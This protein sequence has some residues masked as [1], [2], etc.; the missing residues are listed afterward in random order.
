M[1]DVNPYT[2]SSLFDRSA[3]LPD[4]SPHGYIVVAEVLL[5]FVVL[6]GAQSALK[7][8]SRRNWTNTD[9]RLLSR[10]QA[11]VITRKTYTQ[12]DPPSCFSLVS[13][14]ALEIDRTATYAGLR[15]ALGPAASLIEETV[16]PLFEKH[17]V[18]GTLTCQKFVR[19][20]V[21][22]RDAGVC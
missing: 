20:C 19:L 11:A 2:A 10:K 8:F 21:A 7:T 12:Q 9:A 22:L 15:L 16:D 17:A 14:G 1:E 6:F 13:G 18:S 3:T 5:F 4:D